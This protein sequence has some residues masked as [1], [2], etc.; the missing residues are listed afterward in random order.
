MTEL[1]DDEMTNIYINLGL[2]ETKYFIYLKLFKFF[3][4]LVHKSKFVK[5]LNLFLLQIFRTND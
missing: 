3:Y 5:V 2:T 4:K 1:G